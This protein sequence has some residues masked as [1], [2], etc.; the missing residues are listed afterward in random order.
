MDFIRPTVKLFVMRTVRI[1]SFWRDLIKKIK[2]IQTN[3]LS[4]DNF[5]YFYSQLGIIKRKNI[6]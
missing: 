4:N 3:F 2:N 5:L 6:N 1:E